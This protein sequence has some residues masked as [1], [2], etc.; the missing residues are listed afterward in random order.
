MN[1]R[2]S[3]TLVLLV[4]P[5]TAA[6][7]LA[8]MPA[9][10]QKPDAAAKPTP[11]PEKAAVERT[12]KTVRMLDDVYKN[13]VVLITEKYVNKPEDFAAGSAAVALFKNVSK[14][15][16]QQVRLLDVTGDPYEPENVAKDTFEKEGVKRIK[17]GDAYYDEVVTNDKG[18]HE[19]RAITSI[20]V[21][22]DKCIM[23]HPNYAAAKKKGQNIGAIS[24]TLPI[25]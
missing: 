5:T 17:A 23:C 18:K 19:L 11:A 12:R 8:T 7:D 6:L 1:R 24:Y 25:D 9:A 16:H 3:W 21:V 22:L 2:L 20:P 15:G 4:L 14:S 10:A 13:A